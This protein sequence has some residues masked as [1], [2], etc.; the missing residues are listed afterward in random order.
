MITLVLND[1]P[2]IESPLVPLARLGP[3]GMTREL[4]GTLRAMALL[5]SKLARYA[6]EHPGSNEPPE[7]VLQRV[8]ALVQAQL[9]DGA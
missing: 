4:F 7:A 5:A 9:L 2:N 1:R 3:G 8:S 6:S